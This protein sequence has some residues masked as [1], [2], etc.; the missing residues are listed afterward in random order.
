MF[1]N[2]HKK[3]NPLHWCLLTLLSAALVAWM[4][5]DTTPPV[6]YK[7]ST[8]YQPAAVKSLHLDD[9]YRIKMQL[10]SL[11]MKKYC[12]RGSNIIFAHNIEF[13]GLVLDD[14]MFRI[15]GDRTWINAHIVQKGH[16]EVRC[17]E[18]YANLYKS[19]IKPMQITMRA[20]NVET[21][22]EQEI[23]AEGTMSCTWNHAIDILEN[24]WL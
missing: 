3:T 22:S 7:H 8:K 5:I 17:K 1:Y 11:Y 4:I 24:N 15:C 10:V 18:E 20:I 12:D 21:W 13:E 19:R 16:K 23:E 14:H 2:A 9:K 6:K